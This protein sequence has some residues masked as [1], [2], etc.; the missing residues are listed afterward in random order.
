[1]PLEYRFASPLVARVL[2]RVLVG[3]GALV[4]VLAL[5]V[6]VLDLPVVVLSVGLVVALLVFLGTG[7]LLTRGAAVMRMDE[8][9]YR[10]RWVRGAGAKQARW[11]DVEDAVATTV[12]GHR[13]VVIRLRDGRTTTVPVDVLAGSD[14]GFVRELQQHLD[15][16]HGY[17]PLA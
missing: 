14:D 7:L 13:C 8:A 15:R 10:V 17:R 12:A 2:G 16:G 6:A 9:G 4:L 5:L 11:T 1:M 3:A